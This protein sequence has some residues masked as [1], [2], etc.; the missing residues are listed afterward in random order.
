MAKAC[1][2]GT[3][4]CL[5]ELEVGD[6]AFLI[7]ASGT[8]YAYR[9]FKVFVVGPE[10]ARV[11]EPVAGKSVLTLQTCTLPGYKQRLIV[12]ADLV[13]KHGKNEM[14]RGR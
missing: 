12:R 13:G 6:K 14:G 7:D 11:T 1:E 8:K 9:V 2:P 3:F 5:N 10:D 4:W